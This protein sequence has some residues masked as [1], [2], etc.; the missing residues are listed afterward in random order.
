MVAEADVWVALFSFGA[1][2]AAIGL[3]T[4]FMYA[5][6]RKYVK[7]RNSGGRKQEC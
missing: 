6:L 2:C 1:L 3:A 5:V 4:S 7:S